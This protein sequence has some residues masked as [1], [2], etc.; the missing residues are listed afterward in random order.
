[1]I[2]YEIYDWNHLIGKQSRSILANDVETLINQGKYWTNSPRYQ[3]NVNVFGLPGEEWNNLKMS[4]VWSCFAYLKRS[5]SIKT[6]K[7]WSYM[8]SLKYTVEDRDVYW[9]QHLR[10]DSKV[11][12]GVYYLKI[13]ENIDTITAGTEFAPHGPDVDKD[14]FFIEAKEGFWA[15]WP[16]SAWHRPGILQSHDDRYIVA[17]DLEF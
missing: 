13:P 9:H 11:V 15:I 7:A 5:V 16:G 6:I 3:T 1:M 2:E 14:K 12:S 10:E 17:A 4:F 8:T